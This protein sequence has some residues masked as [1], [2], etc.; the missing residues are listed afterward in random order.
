MQQNDALVSL[1]GRLV[2]VGMRTRKRRVGASP[3][4]AKLRG[5]SAGSSPC[6]RRTTAKTAGASSLRGAT[7]P[8]SS[9]S[10]SS[11]VGAEAARGSSSVSSP[12]SA[13]TRSLATRAGARPAEI[14]HCDARAVVHGP[15]KG[16][17]DVAGHPGALVTVLYLRAHP[18]SQKK[19]SARA[20]EGHVHEAPRLLALLGGGIRG[21]RRAELS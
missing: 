2:A 17:K 11:P 8:S 18:H 15:A 14:H 10:R 19:R 7:A 12:T 1:N 20:R 9:S 3:S 5:A 21:Q 4:R 13:R 16:V 6:S